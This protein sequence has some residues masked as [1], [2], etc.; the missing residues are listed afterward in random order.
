MGCHRMVAVG[1]PEIQRLRAYFDKNEPVRWARIV[2]EPDFVFFNHSPHIMKG[3][4]CQQCH[5]PVETMAQVRLDHT[6]SMDACVHCHRQRGV[7]TDCY[8]CHR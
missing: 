2:K 4:R 7:S 1:K 8:T 5:G 3:V 6:L